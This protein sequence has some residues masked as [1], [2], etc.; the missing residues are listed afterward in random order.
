MDDSPALST[1]DRNRLRWVGLRYDF[2]LD[3]Y[4]VPRKQRKALRAELRSNLTDAACHVGLSAAL[5]NSAAFGISPQR[6][7]EKDSCARAGL[8]DSSPQFQHL[9]SASSRF[10]SSRRTT[11]KAYSTRTPPRRSH[12]ACSPSSAPPSPS[13]RPAVWN[14]RSSRARCRSS[15]PSQSGSSSRLRGEAS[16]TAATSCRARRSSDGPERT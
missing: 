14:S 1:L 10:F 5:A 11:Q 2:W 6:R 15:L 12:R 9:R 4:N 13:I 8:P 3:L 7:P 16:V